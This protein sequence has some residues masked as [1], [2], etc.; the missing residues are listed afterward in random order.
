MK[1]LL[2][3]LLVLASLPVFAY[4][5]SFADFGGNEDPNANGNG[6]NDQNCALHVSRAVN[7]DGTRLAY[8]DFDRHDLYS[9]STF[10]KKFKVEVNGNFEKRNFSIQSLPTLTGDSLFAE[11][12]GHK[13]RFEIKR[14]FKKSIFCYYG[15]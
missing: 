7:S 10:L 8:V 3:S 5:G 1:N 4:D 2:L 11:V 9:S 6:L 13:T 15:Y 12:N 14:P